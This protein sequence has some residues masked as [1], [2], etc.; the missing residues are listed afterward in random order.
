MDVLYYKQQTLNLSLKEQTDINL[1]SITNK[2][3]IIVRSQHSMPFVIID[4]T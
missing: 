3:V 1:T 2:P 4:Q